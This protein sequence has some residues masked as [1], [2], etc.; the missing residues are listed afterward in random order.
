[1]MQLEAD[2]L[3]EVA[4]AEKTGADKFLVEQK[5]AEAKKTLAE[6][7]TN[8][9][10]DLASGLAGNLATIFG[11]ETKVGKAAASAQIAIDTYK[12]A[13]AAYSSLAAFPPL[14]I[15]AAAAVGVTGAKAIKDVWAVKEKFAGGGIVGGSS[16]TGDNV[17]VGVNSGEMILN[18]TQQK[19]LFNAIATNNI[20][21]G[22]GI[23]YDLL[24]KAVSRQ[25]APVLTYKEFADYQQ[26]ITTF[27]EIIKL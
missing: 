24:A 13:M 22:G 10:L 2:Y 25:P 16:L 23:D 7:E 5:Y 18:S 12:G 15:A 17:R 3:A 27:D 9:K 26:K 8:A 19:S 20:P 21:Q 4:A 11:K 14:A 1:L 6:Q